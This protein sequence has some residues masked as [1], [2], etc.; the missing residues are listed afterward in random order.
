[1]HRRGN[2]DPQCSCTRACRKR[3]TA[4]LGLEYW[5]YISHM[6]RFSR[7]SRKSQLGRAWPAYLLLGALWLAISAAHKN[8]MPQNLD[9]ICTIF[10]DRRDWYAA[11]KKSEERWGTPAHIQMAIIQQES[12]FRFNAR[13]PRTKIMGFIPWTRQSNAYGYA[14]ALDGTWVRYKNDTGRW[15]ADRDDFDDAIDFIGW[16]TNLSNKSAGISKWDPYNQYLA[17]HEGQAGWRRGSYHQNNR[18]KKSARQVDIRARQWS[19]QLQS[20]KAA[21]D[22]PWWMFRR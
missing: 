22:D 6:Q 17:Y 18:L 10:E 12:S 2:G 16:Y 7:K 1:M 11:A 21:L 20:C 13:P 14:Q 8:K 9:D 15:Y 19:I 3:Y 4:V 5:R